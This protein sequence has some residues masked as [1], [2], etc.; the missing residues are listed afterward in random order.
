M[1]LA[2][3]LVY[4]PDENGRHINF[5]EGAAIFIA[6]LIHRHL[7]LEIAD[8]ILFKMCQKH[9]KNYL[10]IRSQLAMFMI[11]YG[12]NCLV[13]R[14]FYGEL[15]DMFSQENCQPAK[16]NFDYDYEEPEEEE[17]EE[18]EH[19]FDDEIKEEAFKRMCEEHDYYSV[20]RK[21]YIRDILL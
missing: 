15:N 11:D 20:K 6:C 9:V 18:P 8:N 16:I 2:D 4:I 17:I 1:K 13:D 5:K 10:P 12:H 3:T 14:H 7:L 21:T 19:Y